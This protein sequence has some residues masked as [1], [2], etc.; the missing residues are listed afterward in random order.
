MKKKKIA[1]FSSGWGPDIIRKIVS[2]MEEQFPEGY[3][4]I[5]LF[6][7]YATYVMDPEIKDK[8]L[9]IFKLPVL[10]DFDAVLIVRNSI[11]FEN[12]VEDISGRC[13]AAGIP[14]LCTGSA[15][16]GSYYITTDNYTAMKDLVNHL[17]DEH[18]VKDPF[19][20]AGTDNSEDSN[21]RMQAVKDVLE[22][23][24]MSLSKDRYMYS[25]W[26]PNKAIR[27][28]RKMIEHKEKLPDAFLC[29]NDTIAMNIC[30][31]LYDN[32]YKVPDDIC[33]TGFD[34]DFLAQVFNPSISSVEQNMDKVGIE[35]ARFF[36]DILSGKEREQ[37]I[38]VP[39]SFVPSESCGC[40]GTR[41]FES[42][43]REVG[44]RRYLD[45]FH[46][47]IFDSD[48]EL[49]DKFIMSATSYDDLSD[50]MGERYLEPH[51]F[52][53]DYLA[54]MLDPL[55]EKSIYNPDRN[56]RSN[57]YSK[58]VK[59]LFS[60]K[61]GRVYSDTSEIESRDLL[62]NRYEDTKN[63]IYVF[64]PLYGESGGY[65]YIVVEGGMERVN[66]Y[67]L[68]KFKRNLNASLEKFKKDLSLNLLNLK[69]QEATEIDPLT[70]VKNSKAF[71]ARGLE[72]QK[73]M[74]FNSDLEFG[75]AMFNVNYTRQVYE[76]FGAE[77]GDD[78]IINTCKLI[79]K[80]F[81][82]SPVYR[83]GSDEFAVVLLGDDYNDRTLLLENIRN[84]FNE[85]EHSDLPV[86]EKLSAG[87][88]MAEYD[89]LMDE[90]VSDVLNRAKEEMMDNKRTIKKGR[91]K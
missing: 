39:C 53:G 22:E 90:T 72:L 6:I 2:G 25:D 23:R 44:K 51:E 21:I 81:T 40:N 59:T 43:R 41:D 29:A 52:E 87:S 69:L 57:G 15:V 11:N 27:F 73:R 79:C 31:V 5:Y 12:V 64:M 88:G 20:I 62:P 26:E 91:L 84:K 33:V 46:E 30:E 55:Y 14:F 54:V 66:D 50:K 67:R 80:A 7:T 76:K 34:N 19:F 24:G 37:H 17:M 60:M 9:N 35:C 45:M 89:T 61:D 42:I 77:I 86:Y 56:F 70:G 71:E 4:D 38:L 18:K 3:C 78:Y 8:E 32:G 58:T 48:M 47:T 13:V 65:G 83:I 28:V 63:R 10:D 1:V 68:N 74:S 82:C 36:M 75:V 49:L 16:E 85:L